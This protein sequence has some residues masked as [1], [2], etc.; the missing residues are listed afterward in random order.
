MN[1][2]IETLVEGIICVHLLALFSVNTPNP[3]FL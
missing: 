2:Y 3:S 1:N